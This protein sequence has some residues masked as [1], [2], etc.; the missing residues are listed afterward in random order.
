MKNEETL[1]RKRQSHRFF[2]YRKPQTTPLYTKQRPYQHQYNHKSLTINPIKIQKHFHNKPKNTPLTEESPNSMV[3]Q[4]ITRIRLMQEC[5]WTNSDSSSEESG[6][7]AQN[8]R[9]NVPTT[10]PQMHPRR[11][12]VFSFSTAEL[13]ERRSEGYECLVGFLLDARRFS[14]E[15]IQNYINREWELRGRAIVLGRD[16]NTFHIHYERELNR[17]VGVHANPWAIDGAI[18]VQQPWNPNIPLAQAR[19]PKIAL[20]LQ[21]WDL[22]F[23]YLQP[24][25]ARR[26]ALS[27]G[28][29]LQID[30]ENRRPRNI[31]FMRVR[32]SADLTVSLVSCCTLER[33]DGTSQWVRFRYERIQKICLNYG[34]I[35]HTHRNYMSTF[36]E[37]ER[38]INRG[39][40]RT[41]QRHGLPIVVETDTT[42]F[43]NQMR[44]YLTRASR[45][46]TRIG[47]RQVP[48]KQ[49]TD[50]QIR[51][52]E[53]NFQ[54]ALA[55]IQRGLH[56]PK[57]M[58]TDPPQQGNQNQQQG[59]IQDQEDRREESQHQAL[60]PL[61]QL[62]IGDMP[63]QHIDHARANLSQRD[64]PSQT[65]EITLQLPQDEN[66][67]ENRE[68]EGDEPTEEM[69]YESQEIERY[70]PPIQLQGEQ[71]QVEASRELV[72]GLPNLEE[73]NT[74]TFHRNLDQ[75]I[76]RLQGELSQLMQRHPNQPS[77]LIDENQQEQYPLSPIDD[78]VAEFHNSVERIQRIHA[79]YEGDFQN[80]A[81]YDDMMFAFAREQS[82]FDHICQEIIRQSDYMLSGLQM[83]KLNTPYVQSCEP[84]WANV[85]RGG[86]MF[87]NAKLVQEDG[88]ETESSSMAK[89]RS[90]ETA[91]FQMNLLLNGENGDSLRLVG[92]GMYNFQ[93]QDATNSLDNKIEKER[94]RMDESHSDTDSEDGRRIRQRLQSL[95]VNE[96]VAVM[97]RQSQGAVIIRNGESNE[98]GLR[99]VV[100]QQPPKT[101]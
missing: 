52:I 81:D 5:S 71:N 34:E 87:T 3:P 66:S 14:I 26:M 94:I 27:A 56:G 33:D 77:P 83:R 28:E 84:R 29:V 68:Q 49:I 17:I 101:P 53:S 90:R 23:E 37:V 100:P 67:L 42:H 61:Q 73:S 39:L 63:N 4:R 6:D 55:D 16:D 31:R 59:R 98:L 93:I 22:P 46:N 85:P 32:I 96:M 79:R 8:E 99:Q 95:D 2:P 65:Q 48:K 1:K 60:V 7:S 18:F 75:R 72:E 80:Q 30:W 57:P 24:L 76:E 25:I 45:R 9:I 10:A 11:S 50:E 92:D 12:H 19:L 91:E 51:K 74:D 47:Y 43:S 62:H 20:W 54:E 35:D 58:A 44:A 15:F 13:E 36:E 70:S 69:P 21:I 88:N 97:E 40:N 41:S 82:R 89:R 78:P 38:R 64:E 86:T